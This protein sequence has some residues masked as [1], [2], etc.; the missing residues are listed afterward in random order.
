MIRI[1]RKKA[2]NRSLGGDIFVTTFVSLFALMMV[3]PLIYTVSSAFKPMDELFVFPP[4]FFP[5]N[6]TMTNFTSLFRV[7]S[8]TT[9]PFSRY[10]FNTVLVS[11]VGTGGHV[12]LSSMCAYAISKIRFPG[13]QLMF[14][15][16]VLSLMFSG[17]ATG[18]ALYIIMV[19]LGLINTYWALLLPAFCSS[20]GLYLMK[21]FMDQMVNDT[22]LEAARIDGANEA[23]IFFKI[24]MP[25]VKPAWL[26]LCIFSFQGLWAIGATSYIFR[27]DLKTM[28]YAIS[29]VLSSGISR[30]GAA[31]ASGLLM[32]IVPLLFFV[33]TQSNVVETMSTS[34][35]KD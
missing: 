21:Q 23:V 33:I 32:L 7:L 20:L 10:V 22:I 27:E 25:S 8:T 3:L 28:N 5:R 29:Q 35:M 18:I 26:T 4:R 13:R 6:P 16:I 17:P 11:I 1:R 34:G 19:K 24:V 12:I 9:V 31:S 14:K 15:S 2:L 30:T